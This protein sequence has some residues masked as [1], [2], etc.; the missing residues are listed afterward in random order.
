MLQPITGSR[1]LQTVLYFLLVNGEAY[2]S[3]IKRQLGIA[4]TPIQR[5][6][7]KLLS[8]GVHYKGTATNG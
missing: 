2:P 8:V 4:L 1:T 7:Q 3:Q 6:F 5:A